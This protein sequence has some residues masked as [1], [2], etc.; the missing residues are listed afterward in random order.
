MK[1][2]DNFFKP[3]KN[4]SEK[5]KD[6]RRLVKDQEPTS[7]KEILAEDSD[8]LS[9]L[10]SYLDQ[11]KKSKKYFSSIKINETMKEAKIVEEKIGK[12][13]AG[14]KKTHK[15]MENAKLSAGAKIRSENCEE[16]KSKNKIL[17]NKTVDRERQSKTPNWKNQ[18]SCKQRNQTEKKLEK[19]NSSPRNKVQSDFPED[20][21]VN[22]TQSGFQSTPKVQEIQVVNEKAT[23]T[24]FEDPNEKKELKASNEEHMQS[25]ADQR[26]QEEV[27]AGF[28]SHS[29]SPGP[30]DVSADAI[31][32]ASR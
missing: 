12:S 31:T 6:Q 15:P 1:A 28:D 27:L 30:A 3:C 9:K 19:F 20:L 21:K 8:D 2:Q 7:E 4:E 11:E 18:K 22:S 17:M 23:Q 13:Q 16:S 10:G 14:P 24:E 29:W 32:P 5:L 26:K 25:H